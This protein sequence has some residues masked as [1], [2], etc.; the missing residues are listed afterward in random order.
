[1][2][3]DKIMEPVADYDTASKERE[4]LVQKCV[5]AAILEH[6]RINNPI[7]VWR[8]EKVVW[9]QPD[10]LE[11]SE[12]EI[13]ELDAMRAAGAFTTYQPNIQKS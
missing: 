9:L 6:K 3:A 11:F 12:E 1:M 5:R 4:R 10:E 13:A 2:Q 8:D 7:C